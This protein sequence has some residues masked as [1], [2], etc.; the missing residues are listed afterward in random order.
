MVLRSMAGGLTGLKELA[1]QLEE[2][3]LSNLLLVMGC[4][5]DILSFGD[6]SHGFNSSLGYVGG[7]PLTVP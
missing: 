4:G 3:V 5:A 7:A 2:L 6:F 1:N